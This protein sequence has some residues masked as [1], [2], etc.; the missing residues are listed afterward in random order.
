[1]RYG[2]LKRSEIE[3]AVEHGLETV[4]LTDINNTPSACLNF[5]RLL[6]DKPQNQW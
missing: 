1:M 4:V 2:T 5:V 6:A 3:L